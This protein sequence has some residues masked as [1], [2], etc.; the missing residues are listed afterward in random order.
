MNSTG[1]VGSFRVAGGRWSVR[2]MALVVAVWGCWAGLAS[3][4]V[5]VDGLRCEYAVN[6]VGIDTVQPRLGWT[7]H[8]AE[9]AQRQS[10]YQIRVAASP[11]ALQ[12]EQPALWDTGK[13]VS[14]QSAHIVY[15]G[16]P[17][18]AG[19]RYHWQVR[20]WDQQDQASP[21][22]ETAFWQVAL[23]A[24]ADW[25]ARWIGPA[26]STTPA[27]GDF[28]L[29]AD[30]TLQQDCVG[31]LF[32]ARDSDNLYMWQLNTRVGPTLALRPQIC[33][34]GQWSFLAPISLRPTIPEA[35]E[36]KPH[37]VEIEARGPRIRTRIDG[38][39]VD[40]RVD[41][42]FASG[43]IGFRASTG[44]RATVDNLLLTDA[45]GNV[46]LKDDF[47][48]KGGAGFPEARLK[49]GQ[50][51]LVDALL[52]HRQPLPKDC[53]RL[54]K[55]FVLNRPV[56]RATVS[57]CGL[58]FYE[59]YLN[60]AKVGPRVLAP[61]N[62]AYAQRL[63][64]DTL[65]V[66]AVVKQGANAIGLWLAPGYSDDYSR[67]GWKWEHDKRAIL[68]L[69]VVF[70]DGTTVSVVTDG[71][72][73]AGAS[74]ITFASLYDGETYDAGLET[75][76]WATAAFPADGWVP[77]RLLEAPAAKLVPN[78]MPPVRVIETL[79]PVTLGEPRP[80]VFVF[81]MGQNFAGWVRLRAQGPRGTRI[82]LHHSELLG[83]DGMLD[84]WT[85]RRA[86]STDTFVLRGEG[87]EVYQP[88]FTYHG[89][90]YVEV[91]GYPGRPTLD[92]V[93]GCVV[94]AD[95]QPAGICVTSDAMLNRVHS[96]CVWGM[97]SNLMSIPTDCPVRDERTPCQMDSLAY[98]EAAL[99][100][101]WMHGYYVKW[102]GEIAGGRGNP[103]WNGDQVLLPWRLYQHYGD[104]RVLETSYANMRTYV[105][106]LHAK[107]PGHIY[108]EGFGDWCPP[109]TGTWESFHGA[110]TE[111]NTCYYAELARIVSETAALFGKNEEAAQY[112]GLARDIAE[113][114]QQKRFDA[115]TA[116][117][118]DGSQTS[119][120]MPLALNLV[121]KD[122][123]AAA[124]DRLVATIQGKNH[125][126]L[127]TGI[128]GTRYLVD[129]L[130]DGGQADLAISLLTHT[131]Y[132]GFGYQIAHGATTTWEQ[133]RFKGGMNSHNHAMFAG[134]DVSLYTRLAGITP[135]KPGFEEIR[136]RP[137]MPT[138]LTF[139][140]AAEETVKGR[141]HVRWQRHGGTL[142]LQ[143]S[144]PVNTTA[145]VYVPVASRQ[146][147]TE[148]GQALENAKGVTV[149]GME[150]A[151]AVLRVGSGDY[152][153]TSALH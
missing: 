95:V 147:V 85:N 140:D 4:A 108:T 82:V 114:L 138:S 11:Q 122:Q 20:V 133:W 26:G 102:L 146:A 61:A 99:C 90:R 152:R 34:N 148:G 97:R 67:Y 136:I 137:C 144:V 32:R 33:K 119:S 43:T 135:M 89:F 5:M 130:C 116:A 36:H 111:V 48:G 47:S 126:C 113:A 103:D 12:Q 62:T 69:D 106:W 104:R 73:R 143:V 150:G 92:D 46:L 44:E 124:F 37:H 54:R 56:R 100:N 22:S 96:N 30:V 72:W 86:K 38:K 129:V 98:E 64:F 53:P 153:F 27:W 71:S 66:T 93:T 25:Q 101:F 10:A 76:G 60:G 18:R 128:M 151:A 45:A 110:V 112:A 3:A 81:D 117:Y 132:P 70:D 41:T 145:L 139:V 121:P 105:D 88:R 50:L 123:R 39:L 107:T 79:R 19:E 118:G 15:A 91:T 55:D 28:T 149:V 23:L 63:L 142:E 115:K 7:L 65:D 94:H 78:T 52:L 127:D 84:P 80:G 29:A 9:R 77:A 120:L 31:I 6:P 87:V 68:Q 42:T 125:G 141:V 40:E 49:Q 17:L 21:W 8:S 24:P 16:A 1:S 83:D 109:N 57:V 74:P 134:V 75:P 58:G 51:E 35:D 2:R 14:D 131:N 13:V 59:L